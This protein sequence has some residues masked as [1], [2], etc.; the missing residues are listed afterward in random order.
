MF[1]RTSLEILIALA[2]VP[3]CG[4]S[5]SQPAGA[6]SASG[7]TVAAK[8]PRDKL[9][10][11]ILALHAALDKANK[12]IADAQA[13][14]AT[15]DELANLHRAADAIAN[16]LRKDEAIFAAMEEQ[17]AHGGSGH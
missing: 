13:R 8:S 16:S 7:S 15:T 4:K 14:G 6:G 1:R 9:A 17:A 3:A 11:E 2:L 5:S 12:D 10:A